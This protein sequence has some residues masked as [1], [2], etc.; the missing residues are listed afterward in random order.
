[1]HIGLI[2]FM[3]VM[4]VAVTI[5][6]LKFLGKNKRRYEATPIVAKKLQAI[7]TKS[8]KNTH[9]RKKR[10]PTSIN[11]VYKDR[12]NEFAGAKIL[13]AED[14]IINQKV[15]LSLLDSSGIE[16]DIANNGLE[17]L[18]LLE[19]KEYSLV[20]MDSHMPFMNGE[21]ATIA[22]RANKSHDNLPVVALSGDVLSDDVVKMFEAG[23]D[24]YLQ[25]PLK[26]KALYDVLYSF[27]HMYENSSF[28]KEFSDVGFDIARG[29]EISGDE[30]FYIAILRDFALKY[31]AAATQISQELKNGSAQNAKKLLLDIIGIAA[32]I[33]ADELK[34]R[35]LEL[36]E[37][38]E[39][40]SD[41]EFILALKYFE[42]SLKRSCEL[43][44]KH[45]RL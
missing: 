33:G 25:K 16:V 40:H 44:Y 36:Q 9:L 5:L 38:L 28:A 4:S 23:V 1:M 32:N 31:F 21:Q 15:I 20:L 2:L 18:D 7:Q 22:I 11:E 30:K 12:F 26:P 19:K 3:L 43:I 8:E 24:E 29:V 34:N 45:T 39:H 42:R 17:A 41:L 37:S 10:E 35:A 27:V 6:S 13:V 14:D